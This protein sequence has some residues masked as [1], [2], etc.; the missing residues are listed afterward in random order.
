MFCLERGFPADLGDLKRKHIEEFILDQLDRFTASTAAT[1]FRCLQQF[2]R[3]AAEEDEVSRSPM[4]GMK[5][6]AV[7]EKPVPHLSEDDLRLIL[8][9]CDGKSF[10][11][12][13]DTAIVRLFIDGGLR[14]GALAGIRLDDLDLDRREVVVHTK[15]SKT[16]TVGFGDKTTLALD[17]YLRLRNRHA[18]SSEEWLWVGPKGRLTDSGIA[19]MLHRRATTAGIGH[20]HPHQFRHTFAHRWMAQGGSESDLQNT[21]GW[22]STQMIARYGASAKAERARAAADRLALGDSI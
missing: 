16:L 2:F 19:Q 18:R 10:I 12:R 1:R 15:G 11:E 22:N 17:R 8:K 20:I 9:A 6:P 7:E 5:P 13:R 21:V 4:D 3:F 14:G